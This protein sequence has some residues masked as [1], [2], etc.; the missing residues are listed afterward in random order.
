[1]RSAILILVAFQLQAAVVIDRIAVVVGKHVIKTSD[2]DR[3]LRVTEFQNRT[4]LDLSAAARRKSAERLIDQAVIRDEISTG[5]YNRASDAEAEAMLGQIRRERYGGSTALMRRELA[6][7]GLTEGELRVELLWQLTVL[8]FIDERFSP[9]VL[10]ADQ[11]IR[12]YYNQHL[13]QLKREYPRDYSVTAL[14]SKIRTVLQGQE[15]N[16]Q[17]EAWLDEARKNQHIEYKQEAFG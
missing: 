3:D 13:A 11:D 12:D 1:M 16:K 17:F 4:P 7:Y 10:V 8:R 15:V 14:E 2:I 5:G 6:R 9:A